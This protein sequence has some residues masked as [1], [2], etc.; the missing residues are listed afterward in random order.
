MDVSLPAEWEKFVDFELSTGAFQS[1]SE[2]VIAGL[3]RLK[4]DHEAQSPHQ[5]KNRAELE[6]MLLASIQRLDR[7]EGIDGKES[8]RRMRQSTTASPLK[9]HRTVADLE[10]RLRQGIERLDRGEGVD[11][12]ISL[13]R[14]LK[15]IGVTGANA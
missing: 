14:F 7:G 5:P 12:R 3:R 13:A 1:P 2:V 8:L 9:R 6:S 4:A 15:R 11:G 10:S